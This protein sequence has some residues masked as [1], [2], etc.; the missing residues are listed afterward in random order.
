MQV[1]TVGRATNG[2][3]MSANG[4]TAGN[5]CKI[6]VRVLR[7]GERVLRIDDFTFVHLPCLRDLVGADPEFLHPSVVQHEFEL[8]RAELMERH[9]GG[10]RV[11]R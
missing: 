2:R 3:R 10:V 6:C 9:R 11:G 7:E 5:T 4:R 1:V 8:A